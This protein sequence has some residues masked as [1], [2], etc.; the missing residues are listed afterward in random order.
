MLNVKRNLVARVFQTD[1]DSQELLFQD[2]S[3]I[4][5]SR[6]IQFPHIKWQS[7]CMSSMHTL[8]YTLNHL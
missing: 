8:P 5:K 4:L 7:I 3:G 2:G 1:V 6:D